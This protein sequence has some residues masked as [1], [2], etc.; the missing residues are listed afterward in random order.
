MLIYC[1]IWT[2]DRSIPAGVLSASSML[3]DDWRRDPLG[4]GCRRSPEEGVQPCAHCRIR[5]MEACLL[6]NTTFSP[7]RSILQE[8]IWY[9]AILIGF[10]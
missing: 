10:W 8:L 6:V 1:G 3:D 2:V 5:T 4:T 9:G 7:L